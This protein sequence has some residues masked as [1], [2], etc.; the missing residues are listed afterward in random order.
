MY[1]QQQGN[2]LLQGT[3]SQTT[4]QDNPFNG[5]QTTAQDRNSCGNTTTRKKVT[6]HSTTVIAPHTTRV[7]S[8]SSTPTKLPQRKSRYNLSA[9]SSIQ[10]KVVIQGGAGGTG[11]GGGGCGVGFA[12]ND[13]EENDVDTENLDWYIQ[14]ASRCYNEGFQWHMN[15]LNECEERQRQRRKDNTYSSSG[16]LQLNRHRRSQDPTK[17]KFHVQSSKYHR[18]SNSAGSS[19][20]SS[21]PSIYNLQNKNE[22]DEDDDDCHLNNNY[23]IRININSNNTNDNNIHYYTSNLNPNNNNNNKVKKQTNT[24]TCAAKYQVKKKNIM[25]SNDSGSSI[26][27]LNNNQQQYY[28]VSNSSG[29]GSSSSSSNIIIRNQQQQYG[30]NE[31]NSAK[32]SEIIDNFC[33]LNIS[34]VG[35][36]LLPQIIL[37][38][39]STTSSTLADNSSVPRPSS[40]LL[41]GQTSDRFSE[42]ISGPSGTQENIRFNNS[43][44]FNNSE[45]T[46]ST[47]PPSLTDHQL[48]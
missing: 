48:I 37:T 32:L 28:D 29:G 10:P 42:A 40:L 4:E 7:T 9:A 11:G 43:K 8:N 45:I 6:V 26:D 44:E 27:A 23:K 12:I 47:S 2:C 17:N 15:Y 34:C 14:L 16:A 1:Q 31:N 3:T 36:F 30:G 20:T 33:S 25:N 35:A 13:N 21:D 24:N 46:N 19:S 41:S 22:Y 18:T 38:D 39:F 5:V